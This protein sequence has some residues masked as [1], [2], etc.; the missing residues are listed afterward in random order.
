[1]SGLKAHALQTV[2]WRCGRALQ[3]PGLKGVPGRSVRNVAA[4]RRRS[5]ILLTID[6]LV[7]LADHRALGLA[8]I[9]VP[10]IEDQHGAILRRRIMCFVLD[11]VVENKCLAFDPWPRLARRRETCVLEEQSAASGQST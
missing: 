10:A 1:M 5:A 3:Q 9:A 4:L 11:R 7:D 2:K 6:C 8:E